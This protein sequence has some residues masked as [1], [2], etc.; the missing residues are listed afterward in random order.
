MFFFETQCS[1]STTTTTTITTIITTVITTATTTNNDN[2]K[3]VVD[4]A[5]CDQ[6]L[7]EMWANRAILGWI[8]D[9]LANFCTCY[10][11][12]NLDLWFVDLELL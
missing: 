10:V 12:C 8:M 6:S 7:Y 4:Q 11:R 5:S 9:N 1:Y 3:F 2:T